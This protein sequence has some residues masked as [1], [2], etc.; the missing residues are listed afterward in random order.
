VND[1]ADR[2]SAAV[3]RL[4]ELLPQ[5]PAPGGATPAVDPLLEV[6]DLT[7]VIDLGDGPDQ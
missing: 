7:G 3:S 4:Y 5:S 1:A 6:P 2:L